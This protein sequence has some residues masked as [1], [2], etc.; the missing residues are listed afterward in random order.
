MF[1]E[2]FLPQMIHQLLVLD[3]LG[4]GLLELVP[5]SLEEHGLHG[6]IIW[7]R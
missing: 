6:S 3:L 7:V 1:I 2:H 5:C 4:R